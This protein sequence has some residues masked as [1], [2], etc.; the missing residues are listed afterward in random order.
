MGC[1]R[2]RLRSARY[3]QHRY[4][5]TVYL[6]TVIVNIETETKNTNLKLEF[7]ALLDDKQMQV[8]ELMNVLGFGSNGTA[9]K[10]GS[11]RF[12]CNFISLYNR[13]D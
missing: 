13:Q 9:A 8:T 12:D 4:Q 10:D 7:T 5:V 3:L 11:D 1:A 2:S 6:N